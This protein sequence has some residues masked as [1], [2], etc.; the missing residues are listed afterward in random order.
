VGRVADIKKKRGEEAVSVGCIQREEIIGWDQDTL[1]RLLWNGDFLDIEVLAVVPGEPI[2]GWRSRLRDSCKA[3]RGRPGP[4]GFG[5][6]SELDY[7]RLKNAL[8]ALIPLEGSGST[9]A[10]IPAEADSHW[11]VPTGCSEG[12]VLHIRAFSPDEDDAGWISIDLMSNA[13][14]RHDGSLRGRVVNALGA[15]LGHVGWAGWCPLL[16]PAALGAAIAR[17]SS[18]AFPHLEDALSVPCRL[19]SKNKDNGKMATDERP[20]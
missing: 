15:A 12:C 3:L 8:E 1:V 7:R 6:T 16:T 11:F 9:D 17:A 13:N 5:L 18:V 14:T 10:L 20:D 19:T 2:A 4:D